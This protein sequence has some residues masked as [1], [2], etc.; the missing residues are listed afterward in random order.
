MMTAP[1]AVQSKHRRAVASALNRVLPR[2]QHVAVREIVL[3]ETGARR[4]SP[5]QVLSWMR[6]NMPSAALRVDDVMFPQPFRD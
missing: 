4:A 1:A 6:V 3:A 2:A 5:S